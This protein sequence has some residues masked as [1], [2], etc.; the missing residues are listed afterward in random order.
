MFGSRVQPQSSN[1]SRVNAPCMRAWLHGHSRRRALP[2]ASTPRAPVLRQPPN[3]QGATLPSQFGIMTSSGASIGALWPSVGLSGPQLDSINSRSSR[4]V[5]SARSCCSGASRW[6]GH[7]SGVVGRQFSGRRRRVTKVGVCYAT[8]LVSPR[9]AAC[10]AVACGHQGRGRQPQQFLVLHCG[11]AS[12]AAW[13][14]ARGMAGRRPAGRQPWGGRAAVCAPRS[15]PAQAGL[16]C[17]LC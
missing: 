9:L 4:L 14:T 12:A 7:F 8:V 6:Q 3:R 5:S 13:R 1:H 10:T 15:S 11:L 2:P 17:I 16:L